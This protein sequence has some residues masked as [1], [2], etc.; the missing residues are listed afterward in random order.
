MS[1]LL[2]VVCEL[3]TRWKRPVAYIASQSFICNRIITNSYYSSRQ[4]WEHNIIMQKLKYLRQVVGTYIER[5]NPS[6]RGDKGVDESIGTVRFCLFLLKVI[7]FFLY[8]NCG[9]SH[10]NIKISYSYHH[11]NISECE[12]LPRSMYDNGIKAADTNHRV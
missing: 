6:T 1:F 2:L 12:Y 8:I 11:K 9:F 5:Y 3:A 10:K 7:S 4:V